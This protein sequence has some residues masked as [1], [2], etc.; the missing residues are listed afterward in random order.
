VANLRKPFADSRRVGTRAATGRDLGSRDAH[1]VVTARRART[2]ARAAPMEG[3]D[4][5]RLRDRADMAA[6][7]DSCG[8]RTGESRG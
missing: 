3:L 2:E 1:L 8:G 6:M 7:L 4:A 5:L